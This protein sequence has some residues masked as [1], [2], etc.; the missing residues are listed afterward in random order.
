MSST[1]EVACFGEH[2]NEAY[3]KAMMS[4]GFKIPRNNILLSVGA[5][6]HKVEVQEYVKLLGAMGYKLYGSLGTADYF[7]EVFNGE[8]VVEP[9]DW[10][11][12]NMGEDHEIDNMAEKVVSMADYLSKKHFDLVINLPM[13]TGGIYLLIPLFMYTQKM[14]IVMIL[15]IYFFKGARRVSSF[16]PTYGYQTRRMAIDYGVPLITDVKCMKFMI[17]A[18]H[19]LNKKIP[20]LKTQIDCMSSERLVRIPGL[21]DTHVHLRFVNCF[22]S[23]F[24]P[25]NLVN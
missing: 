7:N 3:L 17:A 14:I 24:F 11:Y 25:Q 22:Y 8:V 6:K 12:E 21:I 15:F 18:L 5:F 2:P 1:G 10:K 13:R 20:K 19:S 16:F 9:V 4:S 23:T